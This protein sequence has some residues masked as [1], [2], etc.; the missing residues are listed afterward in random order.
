MIGRLKQVALDDATAGMMLAQDV[1]DHQGNVLLAEGASLSDS[2][3][4]ALRRRGV[5]SVQV[6]GDSVSEAELAAAREQAQA[7]LA[8]LFRKPHGSPADALLREQLAAWR[9]EQLQ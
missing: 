4:A 8:Q 9:M 3:L 1:R 7:R 6:E 5:E 2:T